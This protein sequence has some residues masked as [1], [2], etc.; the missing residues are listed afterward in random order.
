MRLHS[1]SLPKL[2]VFVNLVCLFMILK[3]AC[4]VRLY[5]DCSSQ[6]IAVD[7]K[8]RVYARDNPSQVYQNFTIISK[9]FT[10]KLAIFAEE[11]RRYLCFNKKWRLIGSKKYRGITCLFKE[12]MLENGY[13]RYRTAAVADGN[14]TRYIGFN[15]DGKFMKETR[16]AKV[17]QTLQRCLYFLKLDTY[18]VNDHNKRVA[19][20][21]DD[22]DITAK[23]HHIRLQNSNKTSQNVNDL[24]YAYRHPSNH[25]LRH[26]NHHHQNINEI[27]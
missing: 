27:T 8:G 13:T 7:R 1:S 22:V 6:N 23:L 4:C 14:E 21:K 9:D 20:L 18:D 5:N 16:L 11:S 3:S 12:E 15:K 26:K 19:G 17:P 24:P 25:K 10:G 2:A